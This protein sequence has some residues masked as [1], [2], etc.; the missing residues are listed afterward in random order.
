MQRFPLLLSLLFLSAGALA[1]TDQN[2][3]SRQ[4][5]ISI[6]PVYQSWSD[7]D[8]GYSFS[9]FS[10]LLA[11]YIPLGRNASF[12][13]GGGG[14]ASGGDVTQL[15]GLTDLQLGFSYYL[16]SA[17]IV[18]SLGINTPIGKKELTQNQFVTSVLFS[19]PLFNLAVPAFG[20][21]LNLNPGI[22]WVAPLSDKLVLGL[23]AA[24]QYRG[25]YKP[26]SGDPFYAPGDEFTGNIGLDLRAS[27]TQSFST[28]FMFTKYGDDQFNDKKVFESG[29]S[30]WFNIQYKQYF[31]DNELDV[32]AGYRSISIG[33]I[34]GAGGL[35]NAAERLEPGR[36]EFIPQ[37]KQVFSQRFAMTYM[38]EVRIFEKTKAPLSGEK[39]FG[40]GVQ[41]VISLANGV[42]FPGR[43]KVDFGSLKDNSSISGVDAGLGIGYS[44]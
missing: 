27:E 35:I 26:I 14:A 19:D 31:R 25:K 16:E 42:F 1:Q 5:S 2:I 32:F 36:F 24:Y 9:E 3:I 30:Y 29:N 13:L 28:D 22:A 15:S 37:F 6:Q 20:Q 39:V 8:A 38:A 10:T 17:N 21:G 44:F 33:K 7:K 4:A 18:F 41:P 11:A 34:A 40:V 12:T 23:A 43:L